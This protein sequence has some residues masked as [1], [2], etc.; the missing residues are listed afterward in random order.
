MITLSI[1]HLNSKVKE[2]MKEIYPLSRYI[3]KNKFILPELK[4][5]GGIYSFWWI[6]KIE[7][8]KEALLSCDNYELKGKRPQGKIKVKFTSEWIDFLDDIG[9]G[10]ICLYVG[11]STD[12]RGRISKHLKLGT[13]N[14][15]LDSKGEKINKNNGR[16]PNT[17]SQLR[18]GLERVF[19]RSIFDG[20]ID[21]IGISWTILTEY[22]NAINRFYL[23]NYFIGKFY[24]LFNI[25]IER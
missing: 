14:I 16:K 11:K 25:D 13:D 6:G 20:I 24:P 1:D 15:W 21:N 4:N 10:K 2:N 7:E 12:I 3:Y 9:N 8:L 18:I 19:N 23:E 5:K 17:E 22:D